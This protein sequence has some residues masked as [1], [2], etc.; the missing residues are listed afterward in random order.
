M[1][2]YAGLTVALVVAGLALGGSAIAR[3]AALVGE[4]R[5]IQAEPAPPPLLD[6]LRGEYRRPDAIPF[7]QADRY[8]PDKALLGRMLFHDTRLSGSGTLACASCHNPGFGYGDGLARSMGRDLRPLD[9][10]SPSLVNAAWGKLFFWDGRAGSLEEQALAPIE[11]PREMD[12]SLDALVRGVSAIAGYR[13]L[14]ARAFPGQPVSPDIIAAAI[15][16]YE[17]T[18]VSGVAPFDAWIEG[19]EAAIPEA[20]K[21]GFRLFNTSARCAACH[22][23]WN[24]SDDGFHD[25]GLTDGDL[26]RGALLP[27]VVKMQHAFKTPGLREVALRAP[28]LHDGSL[29]TLAA[30]VAAYDAGGIDR[31]SRSELVGPLGLSADEQADIV[32]FLQTLT[33]AAAP[34]A[35]VPLPR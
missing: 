15:A 24:F 17:R 9:R 32:A 11:A 10:R 4:T 20:A 29:P 30:V 31:P 14:F 1:L 6:Q 12:R 28:Y 22:G 16:T 27:R 34:G 35:E 3:A 13:S 23:G 18:L 5:H 26:G 2:R 7:P 8:T 33:S 25:T 19:D 21:R